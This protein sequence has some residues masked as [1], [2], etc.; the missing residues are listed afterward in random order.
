MLC[1]SNKFRIYFIRNVV[2]GCNSFWGKKR[3]G[4]T[5]MKSKCI[6]LSDKFCKMNLFPADTFRFSNGND[7]NIFQIRES[8]IFYGRRNSKVNL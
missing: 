5:K 1:C 6:I 3:N 7:F 2:K 4:I 8:G